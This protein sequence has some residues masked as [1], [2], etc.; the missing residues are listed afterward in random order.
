[1]LLGA[2]SGRGVA[3]A[4][5]Q[6]GGTSALLRVPF[7]VIPARFGADSAKRHREE[8][9]RGVLPYRELELPSLSIDIDVAE[10]LQEALQAQTLGHR[11][12]E[13]L[14]ALEVEGA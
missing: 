12:R 1:M 11:T 5:S 14:R 3:L 6:D 13:V 10:N 4:P 8:A 2:V 7:D 9:H